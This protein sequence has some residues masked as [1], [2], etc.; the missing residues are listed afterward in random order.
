MS[1]FAVPYA[2]HFDDTMAYG[3]H[4]FLT[5]FKLQCEGRESLLFG[6]WGFGAPGV[7]DDFASIHLLTGEAYAQT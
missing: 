2:I 7:R 4:H 6:E 1:Y 5:A 3:G